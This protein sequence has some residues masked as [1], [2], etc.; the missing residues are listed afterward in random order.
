MKCPS[1]YQLKS[2]FHLVIG[3]P[4]RVRF[5]PESGLLHWRT[6]SKTVGARTREIQLR[7]IRE[8]DKANIEERHVHSPF[9]LFGPILSSRLAHFLGHRNL[10]STARYTALATDRFAKFW[11]DTSE[12]GRQLRRPQYAKGIWFHW[13]SKQAMRTGQ[14]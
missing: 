9:M 6:C 1:S 13:R 8:D 4:R 11:Q 12:R 2:T 5:T 3:T 7:Q 14:H 10:Q